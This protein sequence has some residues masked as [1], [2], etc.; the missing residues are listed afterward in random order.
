VLP[1]GIT[2]H[3]LPVATE[4]GVM[5]RQEDEPGQRPLT[6]FL[7]DGPVTEVRVDPPVRRHGTEVDDTD[8]TSGT[9]LGIGLHLRHDPQTTGPDVTKRLE[10]TVGS[11]RC[12]PD[13][14]WNPPEGPVE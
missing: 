1:L 13:P 3:P 8:M 12:G 2:D 10:G 4:L 6:E 5:G 7:D 9:G 11:Q 14:Y